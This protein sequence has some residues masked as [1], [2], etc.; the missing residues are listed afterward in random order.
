MTLQDRFERLLEN[1]N[2]DLATPRVVGVRTLA[3]ELE[4]DPTFTQVDENLARAALS[5]L[6]LNL[7]GAS[8]VNLTLCASLGPKTTTNA[9]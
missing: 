3:N 9:A 7:L 2:A 1:T 8:T 6:Y 5:I 4:V